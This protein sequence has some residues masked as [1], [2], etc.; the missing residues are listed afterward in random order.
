MSHVVKGE[1]L[2]FPQPFSTPSCMKSE[3]KTGRPKLRRIR[4]SI[5]TTNKH[6]FA[7][8]TNLRFLILICNTI[9]INI[10]KGV[11]GGRNVL[12]NYH[13]CTRTHTHT[14]IHIHIYFF[15]EKQSAFC[16]LLQSYKMRNIKFDIRTLGIGSPVYYLLRRRWCT[17]TVP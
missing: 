13:Y 15:Y 10:N 6:L 11:L 12:T 5:R 4:N 2:E 1:A 17:L 14:H 3:K 7:V 9:N 16:I 8:N